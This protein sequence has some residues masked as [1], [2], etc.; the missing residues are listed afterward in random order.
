MKW[1]QI[2]GLTD[3]LN[4]EAKKALDRKRQQDAAVLVPNIWAEIVNET[5]T[6][7]N[8]AK[9]NLEVDVDKDTGSISCVIRF[10]PM[11]EDSFHNNKSFL[12]YI[13]EKFNK[14]AENRLKEA[15]N[16]Y[17]RNALVQKIGEYRLNLQNNLLK[18]EAK[19]IHDKRY[20]MAIDAAEKFGKSTYYNP[21]EYQQNLQDAFIAISSLSLPE[22]EKDALKRKMRE[23]I[24]FNAGLGT[25]HVNPENLINPDVEH[26]WKEGLNVSQI[27]KLENQARNILNQQLRLTKANIKNISKSHFESILNTGM[28][29]V[30]FDDLLRRSVSVD[31]QFY[32]DMQ[33]KERLYYKAFEGLQQL[34]YLPLSDTA[35]ILNSFAPKAGDKD[36]HEKQRMYDLLVREFKNQKKLSEQDPAKFVE[37]LFS[38]ELG[39]EMSFTQRLM[40]RKQLQEDKGVQEVMYLTQEERKGFLAKMHSDDPRVVKVEIDKIISLGDESNKI[41]IEILDEI[42][43]NE[44][45]KTP[46]YF[47]AKNQMLGNSVADDFLQIIP[48]QKELFS[49]QSTVEKNVLKK[50]IDNN[51]TYTLWKKKMLM[52][53]PYNISEVDTTYQ[54]IRHLARYYQITEQI[55]EKDAAKKAVQ[56]MIEDNYITKVGSFWAWN[57]S[58]SELVLP[59]KIIQDGSVHEIDEAEVRNRLLKIRKDIID[60]KIEFAVVLSLGEKGNLKHIKNALSNGKFILNENKKGVYFC[61][62]DGSEYNVLMHDYD[63]PLMF[64]LLDLE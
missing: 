11:H 38:D 19:I 8:D 40:L 13:V 39:P 22:Y 34:K 26:P 62:Y 9:N 33:E 60:G 53:Q 37:V 47:Y 6:H 1:Q 10:D 27:I 25:L 24:S 5:T 56:K 50:E 35:Q 7:L 23:Q 21:E 46:V 52:H 55:S 15:K 58:L 61:D 42:L 64:N 45:L 17:V 14:R 57:N 59:K 20:S 41:G 30:G 49:M 44:K 31:D 48:R 16:P 63:T 32:V 18:N 4:T 51:E 43:K 12:S 29:V 3:E 2:A 36:Y 28:G 54:G